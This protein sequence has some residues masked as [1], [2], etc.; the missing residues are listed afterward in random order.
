MS[1]GEGGVGFNTP[2]GASSE[3][4]VAD[5]ALCRLGKGLHER[6]NDVVARVE[7]LNRLGALHGVG[8]RRGP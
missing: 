1:F 3:G 2:A 7:R 4:T 6:C 5:E 8:A